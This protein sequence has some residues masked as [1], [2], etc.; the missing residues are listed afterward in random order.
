M[1]HAAELHRC[2]FR[3]DQVR[4]FD[5]T[6]I[7]EERIPGLE[8][9]ERAGF[10][11]FRYLRRRWPNVRRMMVV[12]GRGNNAGDGYVVAR[13]AR[14][15]GLDVTVC[16]L[17]NPEN[18]CG[19]ARTAYERM[20]RGEVTVV[21]F[22]IVPLAQYELVVDALLG[23]GLRRPVA[24][25]VLQAVEDI[26]ASDVPVM[27]LDVP[28]GLDADTGERRG[29]AINAT[30][31]VSFVG[32]K[33]G[34][35]TGVGPRC[36]GHIEFDDLAIPA[37]V[38]AEQSPAARLTS[39]GDWMHLLPRRERHA[40]KGHFGHVLV[41]GSDVG[42]TG[43]ARLTA[44]AAARCGAGLITIATRE[45]HATTIAGER[46]EI[47]G[48][49]VESASALRALLERATVVAIGPGLGQGEW[50]REMFEAV[51][52]C[53]QPMVMDADAL[54]FLAQSPLQRDNWVLTPH[55]GEAARLLSTSNST[56]EANRFDAVETLSR[57][58][59]A[60][61]VL[62]GAGTLLSADGELTRVC[63]AGN[64]GMGSGGMGDVLTG[65]I[66]ALI[67]QHLKPFEAACLGVCLHAEA[68]DVAAIDGERGLLAR[69]LMPVLRRL[70]N[71]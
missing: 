5:R 14:E 18:L 35:F 56:I 7:D 37:R 61:V 48:R 64:P 11:A 57:Q 31:T 20:N 22:P 10:G 45:S 46:A 60:S 54:N 6:A 49:G 17:G 43:A 67:A 59:G 39:S 41:V 40:H 4:E 69:D 29:A 21:D 25:E 19:D 36:S 42:Y 1:S 44:E 33:R 51:L 15:A 50:G 16:T 53:K 52:A 13:H 3:T 65:V 62:K 23:T 27:S 30:V 38:Y 71:P 47:M 26:N 32:L 63:T 34:L 58:Y 8:L 9:M 70:V 55:P 2:L 12:C 24:G 28:S 68:G 66:A